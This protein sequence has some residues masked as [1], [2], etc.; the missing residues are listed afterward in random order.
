[1]LRLWST[2]ARA[3]ECEAMI[4]AFDA[5]S[6]SRMQLSEACEMSTMMPSALAR[7]T[8]ARPNSL[9]PVSP[10]LPQAGSPLSTFGAELVHRSL[11]PAC[12]RP[13]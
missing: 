3:E 4:G 1:M 8:A 12:T 11:L 2:S 6:A 5:A 9:M 7:A 13:R 10:A